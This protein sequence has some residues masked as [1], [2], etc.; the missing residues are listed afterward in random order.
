MAIFQFKRA[1]FR[2]QKVGQSP[3]AIKINVKNQMFDRFAWNQEKWNVVKL[4]EFKR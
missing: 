4:W 1:F 3:T 2:A